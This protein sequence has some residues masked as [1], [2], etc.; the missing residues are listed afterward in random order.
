M[1]IEGSELL[2]VT[3]F[4]PGESDFTILCLHCA[5]VVELLELSCWAWL[6]KVEKQVE[7]RK[8]KPSAQIC[9]IC[10]QCNF[11]KLCGFLGIVIFRIVLILKLP[12]NPPSNSNC[13]QIHYTLVLFQYDTITSQ[14]TAVTPRSLTTM[15]VCVPCSRLVLRPRE[16]GWFDS[17]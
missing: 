6:R 11:L 3:C 12:P 13:P 14:H 16:L 9:T 15:Y 10:V 1:M 17:S 8:I 7:R 4:N 5:W 2:G